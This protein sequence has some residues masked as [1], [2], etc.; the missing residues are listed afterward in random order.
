MNMN[1]RN[2]TVCETTSVNYPGSSGSAVFDSEGNLIAMVSGYTSGWI[3]VHYYNVT[4]DNICINFY[5][6]F[7]REVY[8]Y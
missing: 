6:A 4:L 2:T 5:E 1:G 7:G 3:G 8:Y